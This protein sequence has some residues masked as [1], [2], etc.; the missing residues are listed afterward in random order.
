MSMVVSDLVK[1]LPKSKLPAGAAVDGG[2]FVFFVSGPKPLL[3]DV[4]IRDS[5]TLVL[6]TGGNAAVHIG[7]KLFSY[8][9]DCWALEPLENK[10]SGEFL[11]QYLCFKLDEIDTLGFEGSGLRHLKKDFEKIP[12]S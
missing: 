1:E 5:E 12:S 3:C 11:Y 10:V 4:T 2:E 7:R 9:T 6:S 8:S